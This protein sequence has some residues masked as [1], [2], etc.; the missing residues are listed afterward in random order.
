VSGRPN[1]ETNASKAA[2]AVRLLNHA[3]LGYTADDRTAPQIYRIV[4]DL[5]LMARR[6]PQAFDQLAA[7]LRRRLA[8]GACYSDRGGDPTEAIDDALAQLLHAEHAAETMQQA[9]DR[10]HNLL[11]QIGENL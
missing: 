6:L 2:E 1:A 11:G 10:A 3:T 5:D 4:G 8:N 9:L 7:M